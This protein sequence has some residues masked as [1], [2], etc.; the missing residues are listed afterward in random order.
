VQ[1]RIYF[2]VYFFLECR[3]SAAAVRNILIQ[4]VNRAHVEVLSVATL[5]DLELRSSFSSDDRVTL[6]S[7]TCAIWKAREQ[8]VRQPTLCPSDAS[9]LIATTFATLHR[10]AIAAPAKDRR[11]AQRRRRE[12]LALDL[13]AELG[14][15]LLMA[16]HLTRPV[17]LPLIFGMTSFFAVRN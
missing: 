12:F 13:L 4:S 14:A 1:C 11:P 8:R 10:S 3:V 16:P 15:S 7:F 17:T 5:D 2:P 6:V 9:H